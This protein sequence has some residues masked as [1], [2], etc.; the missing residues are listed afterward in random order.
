[1]DTPTLIQQFYDQL[2]QI[3]SLDRWDLLKQ[4]KQLDEK[5]DK[6][7]ESILKT[8]RKCFCV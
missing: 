8:E 1:M 3:T 4:L 7:W 6:E 2:E 5:I